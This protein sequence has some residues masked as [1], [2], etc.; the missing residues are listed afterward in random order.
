V[1]ITLKKMRVMYLMI[2]GEVSR[3]VRLADITEATTNQNTQ[4]TNLR[5]F[6]GQTLSED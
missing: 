1:E 3:T 4:E 6:A 2:L 5:V